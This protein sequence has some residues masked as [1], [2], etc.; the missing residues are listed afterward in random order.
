M[1]VTVVVAT[2][3]GHEWVTLANERA[4]PSARALGVPVVHAH[5]LTLHAARNAG[6]DQVATPWTCFL[7]ADD[8]LEPGYFDEME[9]G[10]ADVRAPSVRYISAGGVAAWPYMPSVYNHTHQCEADCLPLG[11]WVI[12]GAVTRTDL[13]RRVGGWH[14]Y[15]IFEDWDLFLRCYKAGA[16]FEGV[17]A[18]VYRAHVRPDSR[19]RSPDREARLE[20]HRMIARANGVPVP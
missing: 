13:V 9:K 14:D 3:G 11:N 8:E 1:H 16:T 18:A 5:D 7:D 20:G 4:I 17:P 12:V 15:P 2:F 6:L 19:N 10:T